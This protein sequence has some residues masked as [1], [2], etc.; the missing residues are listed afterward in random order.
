MGS[1]VRAMV[2]AT[3]PEVFAQGEAEFSGAILRAG[4]GLG[5]TPRETRA[6]CP[7]PGPPAVLSG[8]GAP[9]DRGPQPALRNRFELSF[10]AYLPAPVMRSRPCLDAGST[11]PFVFQGGVWVRPVWLWH[12]GGCPLTAA[13]DSSPF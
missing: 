8:K 2:S 6:R 11:R 13:G 5:N 10:R 12:R 7:L 9:D 4:L 1:P 3:E